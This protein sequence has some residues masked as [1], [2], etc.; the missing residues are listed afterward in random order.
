MSW[1]I[2]GYAEPSEPTTG[3]A[4]A[5]PI[6]TSTDI[7]AYFRVDD[8]GTLHRINAAAFELGNAQHWWA[9]LA[10][11]LVEDDRETYI[12]RQAEV[13]RES[14]TKLRNLIKAIPAPSA[15]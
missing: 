2:P 3:L 7:P 13:L 14:I 11:A 1:S 15:K 10:C 8:L 4:P 6:L 5:A 9:T 12:T